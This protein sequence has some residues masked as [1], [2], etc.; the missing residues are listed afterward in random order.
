MSLAPRH[1]HSTWRAATAEL[2]STL[3]CACAALGCVTDLDCQLNG[4]C[5]TVGTCACD[6]AWGGEDCGDLQLAPGS[7]AYGCLPE[8]LDAGAP[9]RCDFTSWGGGPPVYDEATKKWVLFVSE[10][11][12]HCGLSVWQHMSTIVRAVADSPAGP[13]TRDALVVGAESH[14]AYYARDPVTK[15][16]LIYHVGTGANQTQPWVTNCSN[17]TTPRPLAGTASPI[18]PA[19]ATFSPEIHASASLRGPFVRVNISGVPAGIA[20]PRGASNPAPYIF[21]NGT[22]LVLFRLYNSS[23][24]LGTHPTS[25]IF[26]M[27]APSFAGPYEVLSE[28]YHPAGFPV[29]NSS[30]VTHVNDEDPVLYRDARGHFHNLNHFTHGH[31]FSEDGLTWHWADPKVRGRTAWTST[32]RLSNGSLLVLRDSERPRVWINE[33]TGLPELIFVSSGGQHQPTQAD[34]VARGFT[35]VQRIRKV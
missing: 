5:T 34:G 3:L 8:G 28:I 19:G 9:P 17:G 1:V 10:M 20:P 31:G 27:R 13:F 4:L 32:L 14:N 11:G 23:V 16:H 33:T 7:V 15:Q 6:A 21:E 25:R 26:V 24:P 2:F 18:G 12:G 29:F 30:A 35:M 22:A